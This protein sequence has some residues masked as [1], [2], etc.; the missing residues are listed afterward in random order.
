MILLLVVLAVI[1]YAVF[2]G[3]DPTFL[4]A[5]AVGAAIVWWPVYAFSGSLG[6]VSPRLRGWLRTARHR[7]RRSLAA[8]GMAV[9]LRVTPGPKPGRLPRHL[10]A[11]IRRDHSRTVRYRLRKGS[12]HA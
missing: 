11:Q 4:L 6:G 1:T 2:A 9:Y 5:L 7:G 10:R 3:A 8:L 12:R